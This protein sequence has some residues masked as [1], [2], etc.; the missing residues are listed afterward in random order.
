M[1][2]SD[3]RRRCI[4]M[5]PNSQAEA[6]AV[7]YRLMPATKRTLWPVASSAMILIEAPSLSV[8]LVCSCLPKTLLKEE[9]SYEILYQAAPILLRNRS[10]CQIDVRLCLGLA[11]RDCVAQKYAC[12]P[13]LFLKAI[14][15]Y[16]EDMAVAVECIFT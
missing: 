10:A 11:G 5:T 1:T 13:D 12:S 7:R 4:V 14:A 8:P 2:T 16:P 3:R 15:P 6:R 9:T